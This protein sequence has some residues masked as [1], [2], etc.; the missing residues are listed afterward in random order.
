[1]RYE[2]LSNSLQLWFMDAFNELVD[3]FHHMSVTQWAIISAMAVSFG[4][5]CMRGNALN[6]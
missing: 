6:R 1:M 4:F 3:Y 5:L 2:L